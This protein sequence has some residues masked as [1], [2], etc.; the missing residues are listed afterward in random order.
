MAHVHETTEIHAPTCTVPC[1]HV[2]TYMYTSH[3]IAV[4]WPYTYNYNVYIVDCT[5]H[6]YVVCT[7]VQCC[8]CARMEKFEW[9]L[10]R[11]YIMICLI[12]RRNYDIVLHII[13]QH[14]F[15]F[16]VYATSDIYHIFHVTILK[17]VMPNSPTP[18]APPK[19]WILVNFTKFSI[20]RPM[21]FY[22]I[23]FHK[24]ILQFYKYVALYYNV[25]TVYSLV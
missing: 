15:R 23:N 16:C 24:I 20:H 1:S 8:V 10:S 17:M 13:N 11:E 19:I 21:L 25:Y 22:F 5:W 9:N 18:D 14:G 7:H 6:V 2:R 3:I 4:N 12:Q